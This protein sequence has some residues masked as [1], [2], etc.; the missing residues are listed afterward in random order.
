MELPHSVQRFISLVVPAA[1]L[2]ATLF[3]PWPNGEGPPFWGWVWKTREDIAFVATHIASRDGWTS[4]TAN[5]DTPQAGEFILPPSVQEM[6]DMLRRRG[7]PAFEISTTLYANEWVRQQI[8]ASAWP[9]RFEPGTAA[10][11]LAKDEA[12]P[13]NCDLIERQETVTLVYCH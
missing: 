12:I 6:L 8:I 3:L 10:R 9:K 2:T 1:V 13:V 7:L 5:L 4:F 11:F